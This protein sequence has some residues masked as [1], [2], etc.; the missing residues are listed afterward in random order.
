MKCKQCGIEYESSSNNPKVYCSDA[1][2]KRFAR[3]NPDIQPGQIQPGHVNPDT[4]TI[5]LSVDV[6]Y[7]DADIYMSD[8]CRRTQGKV[9]LPGDPGYSG[10][11]KEI[12]GQWQVSTAQ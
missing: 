3:S 6:D 8:I 1:C 7:D 9:T 2:R 4:P 12:D 5:A 10:V 11:C